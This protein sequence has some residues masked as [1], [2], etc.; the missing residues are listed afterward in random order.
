MPD[1]LGVL[2]VN[3]G[4]PDAPTPAAVRR[5][6]RQFLGDP[7]VI[8]YPRA[9]WWLVLNCVILL[10]RPPRSARAYQQIW[11]ERGSPLLLHSED[12]ASAVQNQVSR[13]LS[14]VTHVELAMTYGN[15]SIASGLDRLHEAGVRRII[16]LPLY[17]QYSGT[18]TAAVFDSVSAALKARL[19]VVDPAGEC[20]SAP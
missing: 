17:P 16:V 12:V 4:T 11:T 20:T 6:L 9:L 3:V 19:G 13:R 15:P 10:I 7:R 5:Y 14:G 1:S 2:L 18:T 8:E